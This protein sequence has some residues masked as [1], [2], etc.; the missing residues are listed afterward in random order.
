MLKL[1][2]QTAA[3]KDDRQLVFLPPGSPTTYAG[4]P[5]PD[6]APKIFPNQPYEERKTTKVD[7]AEEAA[8]L[9]QA[10][11]GRCGRPPLEKSLG[12]AR[13]EASDDVRNA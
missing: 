6:G 3:G 8:A 12:E 11:A 10:R 5:R 1:L 13:A 7:E 9:A 4:V 2:D